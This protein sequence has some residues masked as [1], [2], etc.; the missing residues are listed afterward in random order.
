VEKAKEFGVQKLVKRLFD[1][2]DTMNL[3]IQ[4]T[5]TNNGTSNMTQTDAASPWHLLTFRACRN[6]QAYFG[7]YGR[8]KE[9]LHEGV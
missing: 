9:R 1:V 5:P 2:V 6:Y 7:R 4:N 3:V 8:H